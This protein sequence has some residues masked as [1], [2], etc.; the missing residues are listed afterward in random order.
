MFVIFFKRTKMYKFRKFSRLWAPYMA[1]EY[2]FE[3]I[4]QTF[5]NYV[6]YKNEKRVLK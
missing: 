3:L 4:N 6:L 5:S 2:N 1:T